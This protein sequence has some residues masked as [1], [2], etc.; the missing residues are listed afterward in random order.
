MGFVSMFLSQTL[1]ISEICL[2]FL[3]F[4]SN[5]MLED[6]RERSLND[7]VLIYNGYY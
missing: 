4:F 2:Q 5:Q 7:S 3:A 6:L 1:E